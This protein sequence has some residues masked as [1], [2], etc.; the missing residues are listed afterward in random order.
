MMK[1]LLDGNFEGGHSFRWGFV[2]LEINGYWEQIPRHPRSFFF[3][4]KIGQIFSDSGS[5]TAKRFRGLGQISKGHMSN[6]KRAP[7]WLGYIGDYT[8]QVYRDYN[9][10]SLVTNKYNG[11]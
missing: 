3:Q 2:R 11:K 6:E 7:G 9:K 5:T 4:K 8:T 10:G 1:P